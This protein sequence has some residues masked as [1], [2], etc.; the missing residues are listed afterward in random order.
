[1]PPGTT[2][3]VPDEV[4]SLQRFVAARLAMIA[5][6]PTIEEVL[7]RIGHRPKGHLSAKSAVGATDEDLSLPHGCHLGPPP[8]LD[9]HPQAGH[10][11]HDS[12]RELCN[13][14]VAGPWPLLEVDRTLPSASPLSSSSSKHNARPTE[15]VREFAGGRADRGA[16]RLGRGR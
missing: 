13:D 4:Q 7:D 3:A 1:M 5:A 2:K 12:I 8:Q 14:Q 15:W 16:H 9:W 10:F 6:I 11:D